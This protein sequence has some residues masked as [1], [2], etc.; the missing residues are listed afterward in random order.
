MLS[1]GAAPRNCDAERY[2]DGINYR[3]NKVHRRLDRTMMVA[4]RDAESSARF[5]PD[6]LRG[7]PEEKVSLFQ[8]ADFLISF[9]AQAF[10]EPGL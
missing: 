10:L 3:G 1:L 2:Q 8:R 7:S 9:P 4:Q 5:F 6:S